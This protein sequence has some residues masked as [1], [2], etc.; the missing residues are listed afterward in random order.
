LLLLVLI[1]CKKE[2]ATPPQ[3]EPAT[4]GPTIGAL[5]E[6]CGKAPCRSY[7]DA[8]AQVRKLAAPGGGP[9]CLR[10]NVGK[11]KETRSVEYSDGFSGFQE[12]FDDKGT[13]VA[14]QTWADY[15]PDGANFGNVP[16]C[17]PEITEQLCR[18]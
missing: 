7:D 17:T 14:A 9:G 6:Y 10:G 11:C 3:G 18:D 13:M 1:A 4:T 5:T 8:V 16:T 15:R 2:R 12:W